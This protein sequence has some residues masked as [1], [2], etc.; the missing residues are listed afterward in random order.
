ME[1]KDYELGAV[2][3]GNDALGEVTVRIAIDDKVCS[4][5]GISTDII[6]ASIKAYLNAIN[7]MVDQ[8]GEIILNNR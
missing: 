3:E 1:L 8:F 4:G 2:T 7:K 5:R 6:E